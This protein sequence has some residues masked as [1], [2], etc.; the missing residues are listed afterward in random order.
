M[1]EVVV[2]RSLAIHMA[3]RIPPNDPIHLIISLSIPTQ[4]EFNGRRYLF[5]ITKLGVCTSDSRQ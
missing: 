4:N 3:G 1:E 2:E 5:F